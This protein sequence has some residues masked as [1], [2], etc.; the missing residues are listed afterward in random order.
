MVEVEIYVNKCIANILF[1][2]SRCK[3]AE[4]AVTPCNQ[5]PTFWKQQVSS[6][7]MNHLSLKRG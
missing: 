1:G 7:E 4:K 5:L 2:A 6:E 3:S